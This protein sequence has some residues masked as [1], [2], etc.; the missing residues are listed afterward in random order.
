MGNQS[1]RNL[2]VL[3]LVILLST[4]FI[5]PAI[6][7]ASAQTTAAVVA[8][9]IGKIEERIGQ[10]QSQQINLLSP[11]EFKAA[12]ENYEQA[13]ADD[14]RGRNQKDILKR[15]QEADKHLDAAS[16][17]AKISRT[18][19]SELLAAREAAL[20]ADAPQ[21]APEKFEDAEKTFE[22]AARK[23]EDG[24]TKDASKRRDQAIS[25][26]RDAEL[27]AIK[28][29]IIGKVHI[30][31]QQAK[32]A[33]AERYAPMTYLKSQTLIQEAENILNTDRKKQSLARE[34]AEEAAYEANHAMYLSRLVQDYREDDAK[35]ESL[36]LSN[37]DLLK[38]IGKEVN[39]KAI[40]FDNGFVKPMNQIQ[41]AVKSLN[42]NIK[43]LGEEIQR[44]NEEL[45]ERRNEIKALK[46][47]LSKSKAVEIGLKDEL[48]AKKRREEKIKRV[49]NL[50]TANEA[51]VIREGDLLKIRLVGL[52]FP[53]GKSD[54][55]ADFFSIL[56]K[57]Q[58]VIREFPQAKVFI[59]GHTDSKGHRAANMRLST[60]R[61]E[62]VKSYFQANMGLSDEQI[63]AVGY[64]DSRPI[65]PNTNE[66]G[67]RQNRRID[68][69]L[70]VS[71]ALEY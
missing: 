31:I 65:A 59:E 35:W 34:K 44:K 40:K 9:L 19:F 49:E 69:V 2:P 11:R 56:T 46:T 12:F 13:K 33:R 23:V 14:A 71:K 58:Q 17:Y 6:Q 60:A 37:E 38:Q 55:D 52:T 24:N 67:R 42:A 8:Q 41:Q 57:V 53:P 68:V 18:L 62:A 29:N 47:D 22:A 30:L 32:D 51:K 36:I 64:G 28:E 50:F 45:T 66:T 4:A 21:F 48:E 10:A 63:Q 54:I 43:N 1:R 7:K 27:H 20:D 5:I 26:Y 3:L 15:L 39:L 25:L 70:D 16:N 61:A